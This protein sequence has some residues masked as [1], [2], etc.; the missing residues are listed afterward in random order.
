MYQLLY[1]RLHQTFLLHSSIIYSHYL[2]ATSENWLRHI[3]TGLNIMNLELLASCAEMTLAVLDTQ[4]AEMG[5]QSCIS[6][7]IT[8][9]VTWRRKVAR[10]WR[11]YALQPWQQK[12]WTAELLIETTASEVKE[13]KEVEHGQLELWPEQLP[14]PLDLQLIHQLGHLQALCL[15]A[16]NPWHNQIFWRRWWS[17]GGWRA[18]SWS[19][20]D[21]SCKPM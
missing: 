1:F 2:E 9:I 7:V 6:E 10:Q 4:G 11:N 13:E 18:I 12:T 3:C 14:L 16:S 21:I 8:T 19:A 20:G 17:A 15:Q 5:G